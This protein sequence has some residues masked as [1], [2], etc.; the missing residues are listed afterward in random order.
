MQK[1]IY[2]FL[3]VLIIGA[4]FLA[5]CGKEPQKTKIKFTSNPPK[6]AVDSTTPT[7]A[8]DGTALTVE[9]KQAIADMQ[10]NDKEIRGIAHK[11]IS[12][13]YNVDDK[14]LDNQINDA[15]KLTDASFANKFIQ[16]M[17]S[18]WVGSNNVLQNY[19]IS[20]I[21]FNKDN[22]VTVEGSAD[23]TDGDKTKKD[24]IELGFFYQHSWG[25]VYFGYKLQ[26]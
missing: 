9:Q 7:T 14:N 1:K 6:A 15:S 8:D 26:K 11:F 22:T 12:I 4:L 25:I 16:D 20:K 18:K 19:A 2:T 13:M 21:N 17:K 23:Y 24:N 5:G 10:K 3:V